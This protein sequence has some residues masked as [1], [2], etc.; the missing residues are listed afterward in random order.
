MNE[1]VKSLALGNPM[2]GDS[3]ADRTRYRQGTSGDAIDLA[4]FVMIE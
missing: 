1:K 4:F 2:E 3:R